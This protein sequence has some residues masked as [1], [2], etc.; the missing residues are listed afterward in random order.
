MESGWGVLALAKEGGLEVHEA[1]L[2]RGKTL[3]W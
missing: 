2:M 1:S 3:E